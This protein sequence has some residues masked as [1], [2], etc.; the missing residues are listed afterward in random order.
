MCPKYSSLNKASESLNP[1]SLAKTLRSNEQL[2]F[3]LEG[4]VNLEAKPGVTP[5]PETAA[6]AI[7]AMYCFA[8]KMTRQYGDSNGEW[9][10]ETL[11][12]AIKD[13][14]RSRLTSRYQPRQRGLKPYID[15]IIQRAAWKVVTKRMTE[16]RRYN[17][18]PLPIEI[19]ARDLDPAHIVELEDLA[20]RCKQL[21]GDDIAESW[22][23][24]PSG[25]VLSTP[26][27]QKHRHRKEQW[28]RIAHLF[29]GVSFRPRPRR[30]QASRKSRNSVNTTIS[31]KLSE[32]QRQ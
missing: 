14:A 5:A 22:T 2:N 8:R 30:G 26:G 7:M 23:T 28:R 31:L 11:G 27:V 19:A 10:E 15:R 4:Y 29:P 32:V 17:E 12:R 24:N 9:A 20:A 6:R 21:L 18:I 3:A 13:I 16:R 1:S 25:P